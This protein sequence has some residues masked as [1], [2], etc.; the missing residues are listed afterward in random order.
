M[1]ILVTGVTGFLGQYV[2]RRL[3]SKGHFVI[4][5][6]RHKKEL[7]F[8]DQI[9][10]LSVDLTN[11]QKVIDVSKGVDVI[12][13]TAA[14]STVW[15]KREDFILNNVVATDNIIRA[16]KKNNIKKCVYISSPSIYT[17]AEDRLN[18]SED[19]APRINNFTYYI[20]TKLLAEEH[21]KQ[22]ANFM[23]TKFVIL[24][25]RGIF[26]IGDTSI[27]PRV[28]AL[29]KKIGI[30]MI[31]GGKSIIDVTHV[32]NV[33]E[34]IILGINFEGF[35]KNNYEIFNITND[36]SMSI[37]ELFNLLFT[38]IGEDPKYINIKFKTIYSLAGVIEDFYKTFHIYSE[39]V[40]TRYTVCTIGNTQTL[41]ID[42][43]KEMLKYKPI[44][45][46]K[47]GIEQYARWWY[48]EQNK[49]S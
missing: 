11:K 5:V 36:Q 24:R 13:H 23:N 49:I 9:K 20:E 8:I 34:S 30:P 3:I 4:G 6:S 47:E 22:Y 41:N 10:Y 45:T 48:K 40:L 44:I 27:I 39:P 1:K 42:K 28:I 7:D 25:P 17:R 26:G 31:D 2:A 29:N 16:C 12:I 18:I 14:L 21:I 35:Y 37:Y 15:G 43:A 46:I 33:V 38:S 32:E 19:E